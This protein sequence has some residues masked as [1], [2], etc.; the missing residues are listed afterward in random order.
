MKYVLKVVDGFQKFK[1]NSLEE[2]VVS[3]KERLNK[4]ELPLMIESAARAVTDAGYAPRIKDHYVIF[5]VEGVDVFIDCA[6]LP[7]VYIS[8]FYNIDTATE[9]LELVKAAAG[10]VTD[11][12]FMAKAVVGENDG[13]PYIKFFIAAIEHGYSN[14]RDNLDSYVW[15]IFRAYS[16]SIEYY[17]NYIAK[18]VELTGMSPEPTSIPSVQT[19]KISS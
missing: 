11:E 12:M 1:A 3:L 19:T 16:K 17:N 8:I 14:F 6:Q 15:L 18:R 2:E 5:K 10:V 7:Q 9:D 4:A 13:I